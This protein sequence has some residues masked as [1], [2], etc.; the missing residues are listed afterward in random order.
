M[1]ANNNKE[2]RKEDLIGACCSETGLGKK[3]CKEHG[4]DYIDYKC[5]YCCDIAQWFCF[6]NTHF[7][8]PCHNKWQECQKTEK[9]GKTFQCGGQLKC[10]LQIDHPPNGQEFSLG[11]GLC[12]GKQ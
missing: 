11:C 8:E 6:G 7:C 4:K 9:A 12:R 3:D 1:E 10:K 2:F 5:R